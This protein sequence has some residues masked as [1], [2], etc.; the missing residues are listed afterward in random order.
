MKKCLSLVLALV[1]CV[2]VLSIGGAAADDPA[3][4]L[5]TDLGDRVGIVGAGDQFKVSV[6]LDNNPGILTFA[7]ELTFDPNV[8]EVVSFDTDGFLPDNS[9]TDKK[10]PGELPADMQGLI[11]YAADGKV[12]FEL[13]DD[14]ATA[15]ATGDYLCSATLKVKSGAPVG[16]APISMAAVTDKGSENQAVYNYDLNAVAVADGSKKLAASTKGDCDYN[17][18]VNLRDAI[19]LARGINGIAGY[20]LPTLSIGDVDYNT[21]VNLRD[22]I[23]MSRAINGIEGYTLS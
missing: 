8:Y 12:M 13:G 9:E 20:D 2:G 17:K 21:K 10:L 18:K 7:G 5:E 4:R 22:A 3:L 16:E 6:Y 11:S 14:T 15:N 19:Y 1:L 23:Y